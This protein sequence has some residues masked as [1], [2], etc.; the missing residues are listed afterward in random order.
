VCNS[1]C[2][3]VYQQ[4]QTA[5]SSRKSASIFFFSLNNLSI[6]R[7]ALART[8]SM[9]SLLHRWRRSNVVSLL[10]SS[11]S[12]SSFT[13]CREPASPSS[14]VFVR[15]RGGLFA[16]FFFFFF[17]VAASA[18]LL[19]LLSFSSSFSDGVTSG[20]IDVRFVRFVPF[21]ARVT[22]FLF[23]F[24]EADNGIFFVFAS[25]VAT[26]TLFLLV[27][28]FFFFTNS[29]SSSSSF[30]LSLFLLLFFFFFFFFVSIVVVF[31]VVLLFLC[32]FSFFLFLQRTYSHH[33]G[34]LVP[35]L[36]RAP[37]SQR[38]RF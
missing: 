14:A 30:L 24:A 25:S 38:T 36:Y 3:S 27:P 4:N 19:L 17:F 20:R 31:V 26:P 9:S 12:S 22:L 37:I 18:M 21:P 5:N 32:I 13:R 7:S 2:I 28:F 23:P 6:A 33:H 1:A 15:G 29:V 10:F 8:S 11:S 35:N 34:C 16:S